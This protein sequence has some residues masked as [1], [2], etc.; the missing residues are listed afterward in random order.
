MQQV[1]TVIDDY[2][3]KPQ[4]MKQESKTLQ[5]RQD[6][7]NASNLTSDRSKYASGIHRRLNSLINYKVNWG[8][9]SGTFRTTTQSRILK[10]NYEYYVHEDGATNV[11][12]L[13]YLSQSPQCHGW[14]CFYRHKE[15]GL[16]GFH[17]LKGVADFL[18]KTGRT[19]EHL[20]QIITRDA[21]IPSKWEQTD[22]VQTKYNRMLIYNGRKFHSHLFNF[23]NI[24]PTFK[25][26]TFSCYGTTSGRF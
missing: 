16:D 5:F 14:T 19:L 25:R 11:V 21:L 20:I 22:R 3:P 13:L 9:E 1:I 2:L 12:A 24:N 18:I 7:I 26:L 23:K 8:K 4:L 17:D 6:L 15:T 10:T